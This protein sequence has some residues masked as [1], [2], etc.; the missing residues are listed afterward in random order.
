M[1]ITRCLIEAYLDCKYKAYLLASGRTG[2]PH[3]LERVLA[4]LQAA[5]RE[6]AGAVLIRKCHKAKASAFTNTDL[7]SGQEV[8]LGPTLGDGQTTF[9]FDALRRTDGESS[10][11][12]FHY[13]PVLFWQGETPGRNQTLLMAASGIILSRHQRVQP[14]TATVIFGSECRA[15][16]LHLT[17]HYKAA[18]QVLD[19]LLA[20]VEAPQLIL[21]DHCSLCEFR[22]QCREQAIKTDDLSLLGHMTEKKI[23]HYAQ[24]G[25]L[26][27]TQLSY[28]YHARRHKTVRPKQNPRSLPLHA[29]AI[30]QKRILVIGKPTFP[31]TGVRIFFDAEGDFD[32]K[33][34]YL[35]GLLI[36]KDGQEEMI[37]LWADDPSQQKRLFEQSVDVLK[38]YDGYTLFHYGQ[39]E[40]EILRKMRA[41]VR[42]KKV[43]DAAIAASVNVLAPLHSDVYFPTY[44]NGLK[45]IGGYLGFSWTDPNASGLQ[46][47]AW[48][49]R[50]EMT[51][52]G[53][54][55][56]KL[57]VYNAEDCRALKRVTEALETIGQG[58]QDVGAATAAWEEVKFE[59]T[60]RDWGT[61][62]FVLPDFDY[63]NKCAYFDY[64]RDK[65]LLRVRPHRPRKRHACGWQRRQGWVRPNVR[66]RIKVAKCRHCG[67]RNLKP[68]EKTG[69]RKQVFDLELRPS[70]PTRRVIEYTAV[71]A[72]CLDCDKLSAPNYFGRIDICRHGL[73]AWAMYQ[74]VQHQISL[75]KLAA[76]CEDLFGLRIS[77]VYI[78]MIKAML[79]AYYRPTT[80]SLM[81]RLLAGNVIHVDETEI[82]LRYGK[83][84]VWTLT[85]MEEV[86]Y[87]YRPNREVGFL[88]KLL[89]D[90]KGVLVSDY[91]GGYDGMACPQ[92]K[93]LIHL[94]RDMN[95]DL[96]KNPF[97][98]E[99]KLL[100]SDF[101]TLLRG[102]VE[103]IDRHG[104]AQNWLAKHK[105]EAM[106]FLD[107]LAVQEFCSQVAQGYKERFA[108]YRDRLFT[109]LD[110]T[111]VPWNNNNAEHAIKQFAHY[112]EMADGAMVESGLNDYLALLSICV[113]CKYKGV[114]FLRFLASRE[115]DIDAFV[116]HGRVASRKLTLERYPKGFPDRYKGQPRL[117]RREI[118]ATAES[119][120]VGQLYTTLVRGLTA[121]FDQ[122]HRTA[123]G[124]RFLGKMDR[125]RSL[126]VVFS[127]LPKE[128]TTDTGLQ[129]AAYLDRLARYLGISKSSVRKS[130]ATFGEELPHIRQSGG[131]G[132]GWFK[133]MTEV[134]RF[135]DMIGTETHENPDPAPQHHDAG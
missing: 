18:Q 89:A 33:F 115:R 76:L 52:G 41:V 2:Q 61:I 21:N 130:L 1:Q 118:E 4:E 62:G 116:D 97:D 32:R 17:P 123:K 100:L 114:N 78:H 40:A 70:G 107:R 85:N 111:G 64:Q 35:L 20:M 74:H 105:P 88:K 95:S 7:H 135:L 91:Y 87:L 126:R 73:K 68:L 22:G 44:S 80:N 49:K 94:I 50:W 122:V 112:R 46:S 127:L 29:L 36:V 125:G 38:Q 92:Q 77:H 81:Q 45:E 14:K 72:R 99:L 71:R 101:G 12:S 129:Y 132:V 55:K 67:S 10:L 30:R 48:R 13:S 84:Y 28:T 117:S 11:G 83:G 86:V 53:E 134:G 39:Y 106:S 69:T 6:Q 63:I 24:T 102:I 131:Y 9:A 110:H 108:K 51:G 54:F 58:Q 90:F 47:L 103:T 98:D 43:V 26:T 109:F 119:V 31:K 104:L 133:D 75:T 56:Q 93:C 19:G 121:C 5:Y 57:L 23:A 113:T 15:R 65:L 128:S 27:V 42:P 120:G 60:G 66:R 34:T 82:S 79:V 25:T 124:V 96:R 59:P 8:I 16:T 37:S 3:D